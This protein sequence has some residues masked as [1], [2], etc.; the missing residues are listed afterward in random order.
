VNEAPEDSNV[1]IQQKAKEMME[2]LDVDKADA[3]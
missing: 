1:L 2:E 3:P